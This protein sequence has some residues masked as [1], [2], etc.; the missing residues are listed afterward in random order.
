MSTKKTCHDNA[1]ISHM[2]SAEAASLAVGQF[3]DHRDNVGR[4]VLS[5]ITDKKGD[6]LKI[7]YWGWGHK[8]DCWCSY[9]EKTQTSLKRR[10]SWQLC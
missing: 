3:V 4:F 5:K 7:H 10:E 9:I 6:N 2:P 8:W 1:Y